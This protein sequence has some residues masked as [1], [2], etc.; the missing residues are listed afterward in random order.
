[1]KT[2]ILDD[3]P[4]GTQSSSNARVLLEAD[5]D[6]IAAEFASVDTIFL[7]TNSRAIDADAAVAKVSRL[8]AETLAAAA[9]TGTDVQFVLR[10]DST[11]RGH[12][13][14]ETECFRGPD[15]V[16]V[17][18]P[19]F[20]AG[21]R[22]TVDGVHLVR[23]GERDV[24]AHDTEYAAD[25][26]FGFDTAVLADYVAQ[27]SSDPVLTIGLAEVRGPAAT[28]AQRFSAAPRRAVILPDAQTDD[29]IVAIAAAIRSARAAGRDIVV[30]CAAPLAAELGGVRSAGLLPLPLMAGGPTLLVCGSHTSGATAQ[31]AAVGAEP[32]LVRTAEALVDPVAAGRA[33]AAAARDRLRDGRPAI[34]ATERVRDTTHNSLRHGELVMT[35]LITAV[36]ELVSDVDV[37][38]AKG[39]ITSAEVAHIGIGARSATV[40]GQIAAGVSA[41]RLDLPDG[42]TLLYIV[43]PGNVGGESTLVDALTAVGSS[44]QPWAGGGKVGTPASERRSAWL[45]Q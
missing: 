11:L 33:A 44:G 20:P 30:R 29:D 21:G 39:G 3:D 28:L 19:A 31:L 17:F 41:W 16:M 43:V 14:A 45:S 25:P 2:V 15:T 37:V 9:R 1:V 38:I 5:A 36:R 6:L 23:I 40:L 22:T 26:V 34:V 4:T 12:V 18:V 10:G 35:A 32:A 27:R 7:Q 13:F 8:R 42:G 24:P